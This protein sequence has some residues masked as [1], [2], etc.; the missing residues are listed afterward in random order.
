MARLL[1]EAAMPNLARRA[2]RNSSAV[3][4][5]SSELP[6]ADNV[7]PVG[8]GDAIIEIGA[9]GVDGVSTFI[10]SF[11]SV[12]GAVWASALMDSGLGVSDGFSVGVC[13][14]SFSRERST[15]EAMLWFGKRSRTDSVGAARVDQTENV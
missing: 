7:F 15:K 11:D 2:R 13:C 3:G 5:R 12:A 10:W 1:G 4:A 6:L 14:L 8:V 9:L